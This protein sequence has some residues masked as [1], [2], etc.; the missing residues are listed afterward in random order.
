MSKTKAG[1]YTTLGVFDYDYSPGAGEDQVPAPTPAVALA[2]TRVFAGQVTPAA[3]RQGAA[4]GAIVPVPAAVLHSL[5]LPKRRRALPRL[6]STL[7]IPIRGVA[8]ACSFR[9][10]MGPLLLRPGQSRCLAT[11]ILVRPRSPC[12][13]QRTSAWPPL[14]AAMYL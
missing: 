5:L 7:H 9:P 8:S 14:P 3:A 10:A 4:A 1:D 2:P 11:P 6:H 13:F 12:R